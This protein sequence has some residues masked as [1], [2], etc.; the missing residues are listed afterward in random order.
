MD[1]GAFRQKQET[2]RL[3]RADWAR[4]AADPVVCQRGEDCEVAWGR[5]LQWISA[6]SHWKLRNVTDFLIATE[7][8]MDTDRPA[9]TIQKVPQGQ[10]VYRIEMS[11]ACADTMDNRLRGCDPDVTYLIATFNRYV[12]ERPRSEP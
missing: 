9:F 3:M 10:G 8:P 12:R 6:N 7:G 1:V 4:D 11:A 2:E 5:A